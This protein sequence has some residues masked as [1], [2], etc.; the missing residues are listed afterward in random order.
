MA[1]KI[2]DSIC[3]LCKKINRCDVKS[4]IACWCMNTKVPPALLAQVPVELKA[5]A[6][7]CN[8]CIE[9]FQ[10]QLTNTKN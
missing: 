2:D 1:D 3:P 8:A 5:K 10:Q 4:D 7:I 9:R 6:C